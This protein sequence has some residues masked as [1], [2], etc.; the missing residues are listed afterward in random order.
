MKTLYLIRGVSGSGKSTL[1]EEMSAAMGVFHIEA[2]H[3]F[4]DVDGNY[5]FDPDMLYA[6][7]RKCQLLVEGEL[8]DG[9]SV[10]VSNTSTTEKEVNVYKSIAEKYDAKFIC[11][12]VENRHGNSNQHNVPEYVLERQR[13]NIKNSLELG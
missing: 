2:D 13:N 6:N 9:D 5:K 11:I 4:Y 7:H 1:A 12:V 8:E 3:F 10:I